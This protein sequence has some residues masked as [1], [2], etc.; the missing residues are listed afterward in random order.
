MTATSA[1]KLEIEFDSP[2]AY[3]AQPAPQPKEPMAFCGPNVARVRVLPY[4]C[5]PTRYYKL[6]PTCPLQFLQSVTTE[7]SSCYGRAARSGE[8]IIYATDTAQ[9]GLGQPSNAAWAVPAGAGKPGRSGASADGYPSCGLFPSAARSGVCRHGNHQP[10]P[11]P[12]ARALF[13]T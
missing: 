3:S 4:P 9:K 7:L 8:K 5:S 6:N 12:M 10:R 13:G 1:R 2:A 11:H